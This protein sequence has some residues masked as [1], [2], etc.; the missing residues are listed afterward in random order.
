MTMFIFRKKLYTG[1]V[2]VLKTLYTGTVPVLKTLYTGTVP[3]LKTLYT[4]TVPVL[5]TLYTGTMIVGVSASIYVN[6]CYPHACG[7][8]T[9]IVFLLHGCG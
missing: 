4:G 8:K 6:K 9:M 5:K 1:T 7:S 2:P 3:V